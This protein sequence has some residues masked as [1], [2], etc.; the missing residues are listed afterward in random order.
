[1]VQY[2]ETINIIHYLNILKGKNHMIVSLDV[3]KAFDKIHHR[4]MTKVLESSEIQG[5]YLNIEKA[6][7]NIQQ[8]S[9]QHQTKWR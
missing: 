6:I 2:I 1:M 4:F 9:S 3:E 5:L 8:T 7:Y